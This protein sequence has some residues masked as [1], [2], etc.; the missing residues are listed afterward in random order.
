[1]AGIDDYRSALRSVTRG[2]WSGVID[3]DQFFD[4]ARSAM[5][6]RLEQAWNEGA[7]E[8]GILP[9]EFTIEEQTALARAITEEMDQLP[10]FALR[11]DQNSRANDGKLGPLLTRV[12]GLW[13]NRYNDLK[14]RAKV[15][16]CKDQ[17][18]EWVIG[19]T[20][21]HCSSCSRLNGKVKRGSAWNASG[22]KPQDPPNGSLA[23]G[24]WR[25][26]C[27]LRQ[28]NRPVSRGPLPRV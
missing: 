10:G 13:V 20:E 27:E 6:R 9:D 2:Y 23:C 3:A 28:T 5:N 25:C 17:K 19:P 18:L 22:I 14:N 15:L 1:M 16:A 7:A 8:C 12:D 24:G 21:E 4:G 26:L 11:I